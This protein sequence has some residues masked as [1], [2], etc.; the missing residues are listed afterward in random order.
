M[1]GYYAQPISLTRSRAPGRVAFACRR[2]HWQTGHGTSAAL[3]KRRPCLVVSRVLSCTV[4][5]DARR[6][7][8]TLLAFTD[9]LIRNPMKEPERTTRFTVVSVSCYGAR[10]VHGSIVHERYTLI[11]NPMNLHSDPFSAHNL[12]WAGEDEANEPAR[13]HGETT[14]Q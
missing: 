7:S 12:Y 5:R 11:R 6:H 1:Y 4:A 8:L 13:V 2:C 14:G 9:T 10:R 3:R